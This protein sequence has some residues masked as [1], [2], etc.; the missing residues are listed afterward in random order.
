MDRVIERKHKWLNKKTIWFTVGGIFILLL[1]Y[2][3]FFGDKSSKLNVEK[4]KITIESII[5]DEFK[6]Y[7]ATIGTVEPISTVYLDAIEGGRVEEILIDEGAGLEHYKIQDEQ[8]DSSQIN[9]TNIHQK[10]NS[11]LKKSKKFREV[12]LS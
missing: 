5:E 9:T 4:E 12:K 10:K 2:N 8:G 1:A 7:F 3:I 6:D 11:K